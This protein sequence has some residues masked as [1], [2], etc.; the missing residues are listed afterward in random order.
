MNFYMLAYSVRFQ[1]HKRTKRPLNPKAKKL[2]K[3]KFKQFQKA[4]E[5][6]YFCNVSFPDGELGTAQFKEEE[7]HYSFI[8]NKQKCHFWNSLE[9]LYSSVTCNNH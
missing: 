1:A 3:I 2:V 4:L 5:I 9:V 6:I 7:V 8:Q